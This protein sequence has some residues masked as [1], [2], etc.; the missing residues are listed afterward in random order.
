MQ[1]P[2]D[3]PRGLSR[4]DICAQRAPLQ[5]PGTKHCFACLFFHPD[6]NRWSWTF[7]RSTAFAGRG[8][9]DMPVTASEEFHLALNRYIRE[10]SKLHPR[11]SAVGL[12]STRLPQ[13]APA[14]HRQRLAAATP[15]RSPLSPV[16]ESRTTSASV[17][18]IPTDKS[19]TSR[20]IGSSCRNLL[21]QSPT[22]TPGNAERNVS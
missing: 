12:Q 8:L 10:Y 9:R 22:D 16:Y 4:T 19:W 6:F 17:T 2:G 3:E 20:S 13:P 1:G 18:I 14:C 5:K 7:T 15:T 11:A 21:R